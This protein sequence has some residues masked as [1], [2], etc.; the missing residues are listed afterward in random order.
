MLILLQLNDC[1]TDCERWST[2][3]CSLPARQQLLQALACVCFVDSTAHVAL[4]RAAYSSF[5]AHHSNA[6]STT[7][8]L[9]QP[10]AAMQSAGDGAGALGD[11]G[12]MPGLQV[13][14]VSELPAG[15]AIEWYFV[16][17]RG[18]GE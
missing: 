2:T 3:D 17:A 10:G 13:V 4:A 16:M 15:A 18:G 11:A 9:W 12:E 6:S 14:V 5:C 8:T 1:L 7:E